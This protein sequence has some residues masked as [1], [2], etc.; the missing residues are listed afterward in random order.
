M[1][2]AEAAHLFF[3]YLSWLM[4]YVQVTSAVTVG[5]A[6]LFDF[7]KKQKERTR[8]DHRNGLSKCPKKLS[9]VATISLIWLGE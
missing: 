5:I 2:F 6:E 1:D 8:R 7:V 9:D 4:L 3:K